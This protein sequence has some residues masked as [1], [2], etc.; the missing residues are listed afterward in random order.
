LSEEKIEDWIMTQIISGDSKFIKGYA[1]EY[2]DPVK[3]ISAEAKKAIMRWYREK[4]F[5]FES[6]MDSTVNSGLFSIMEKT[7]KIHGVR[8]FFIDNMMTATDESIQDTVRAEGAFVKKLKEFCLAY[9]VHVFLVAHPNKQGSNEYTPLNKVDV[10]GSK[11][12]TNAADNV[13]AVERSWDPKRMDIPEMYRKPVEGSNGNYYTTIVRILKNRSNKP[14]KDLFYRF[15]VESSRFFSECV[16]RVFD[17]DWK[18]FLKPNLK[19]NDGQE[20]HA[21]YERSV[22]NG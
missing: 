10:N 15:H 5:L 9:N 4:F 8:I 7:F 3:V 1:D 12:I 2:G 17:G 19:I 16:P 11:V 21:A 18:K 13:I 14:R 22:Q 6:K 20:N